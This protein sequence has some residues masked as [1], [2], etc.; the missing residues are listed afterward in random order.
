MAYQQ[1]RLHVTSDELSFCVGMLD[2]G[3]TQTHEV[4]TP[5]VSQ[6]VVSRAWI[7]YHMSVHRQRRLQ[8]VQDHVTWT[9]PDWT[10]VLFTDESRFFL[11]FTDG[12]A[13]GWRRAGERHQDACI[14]EPDRYCS[15]SLMA[16]AGISMGKETDL[17]MLPAG[18]HESHWLHG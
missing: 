12:R 7:H 15:G 6:S 13:R 2:S 18:Y 10:T 5:G 17:H 16:W 14:K 11:D 9:V 1:Q 8:W 3:C 4:Q